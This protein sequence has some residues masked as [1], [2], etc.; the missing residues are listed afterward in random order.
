MY[1]LSLCNFLII[2]F[3]SV[4]FW[5]LFSVMVELAREITFFTFFLFYLFF[6]GLLRIL[7]KWIINPFDFVHVMHYSFHIGSLL[8]SFWHRMC[9]FTLTFNISTTPTIDCNIWSLIKISHS[10]LI[11]LWCTIN[12]FLRSQFV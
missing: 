12:K 7:V 4:Y 3:C 10:V 2:Y 6:L 9:L 8:R 11:L 1:P 5:N